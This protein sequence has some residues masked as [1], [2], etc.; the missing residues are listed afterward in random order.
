MMSQDS[1][2]AEP[3]SSASGSPSSMVTVEAAVSI[4]I[5]PERAGGP[6]PAEKRSSLGV[7]EC[8]KR[9]SGSG[10]VSDISTSSLIGVDLV[11]V[12]GRDFWGGVHGSKRGLICD[13]G[14]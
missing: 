7:V 10:E 6:I 14:K 2:P 4:S 12:V 3:S 13:G 1:A 11:A 9:A 8:S 5:P